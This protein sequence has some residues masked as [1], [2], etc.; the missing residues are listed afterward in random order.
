MQ[1]TDLLIQTDRFELDWG[2][3]DDTIPPPGYD[4]AAALLKNLIS[5]GVESRRPERP[6]LLGTLQLVLLCRMGRHN[7]RHHR[8]TEL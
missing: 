5:L 8:P 6:R 1:S 7:L 3:G 2:D 4:L